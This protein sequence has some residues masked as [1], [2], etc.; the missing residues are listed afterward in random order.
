ML[1][2]LASGK[3]PTQYLPS[4]AR[5]PLSLSLSLS[6]D[7]SFGLAAAAAVKSVRCRRVGVHDG[8]PYPSCMYIHS[9]AAVRERP[10]GEWGERAGLITKTQTNGGGGSWVLLRSGQSVL[11]AA[12]LRLRRRRMDYIRTTS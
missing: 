3:R 7:P 6:L 2:T 12:R 8:D 5:T 9:P 4:S 11:R 10:V 1:G